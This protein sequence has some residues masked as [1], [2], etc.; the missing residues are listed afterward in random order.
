M[1]LLSPDLR[2]AILDFLLAYDE[3]L[4]SKGRIG[5]LKPALNGWDGIHQVNW[6]GSAY[7]F[8][9]HLLEITPGEWLKEALRAVPSGVDAAPTVSALCQRIEDDA[10]RATAVP[11]DALSRY[12]QEQIK[13]LSGSRYQ[14]DNR[15][16][17]L[18]LLVDQGPDAQGLRFVPDERRGKYNSLQTLLAEVQER[19]L[20][21]L[22]R[23]GCGKTTL[24]RRLQLERAWAGPEVAG[25]QIPFFVPLNS[26][27]GARL[28]DP[29][30]DPADWLAQ[31]WQQQQPDLPDFAG[32]LGKGRLLLL[33][34]GLNEM[35]HRDRDDFEER[36]ALW[37]LFV[38]RAAPLGNTL[39]FSC[40][41]LDYSVS[42]DSEAQPVRQVD[43]EPLTSA[44]IEQ[45]LTLYLGK[46]A[47]EV[48]A[49]LRQDSQQ[50]TLFATPFFL[51]LLVDQKL[52][53]GE[54]LTSRVAL[55]TGFVRRAL[56]RELE[57][58]H[59]RLFSPGQLLTAS[60]GQQVRQNKWATPMDLPQQGALIPRLA[61]LAYAMQDGRAA[62]EAGQIRIPEETA[63]ALLDHPLAAEIVAA[64]VQLNVLD[65]DMTRQEITCLHQLL[66]EYFAARVL[67]GRPEPGRVQSAWRADELQPRLTSWLKQADVSTPLPPA[68]TT[69]WEETT[70]L[71]AAL[72]PDAERFVGDLMAAN[73]PLAAR[74]A[75]VPEIAA[76]VPPGLLAELQGALLAR[77]GD[78]RADLRARIAAA[79]ALG[80]LGDPRFARR[81]GKHGDYLLP[82]VVSVS[83][84][85]YRIG[86]EERT[87]CSLLWRALGRRQ[88]AAYENEKPA[89]EV[90]IDTF[91]MAAFPAG[92]W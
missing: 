42:L 84:G 40:R 41:S 63:Y 19:A 22:G 87:G 12:Y 36:V 21:L 3:L 60:D 24:L 55:L 37:R 90:W 79:E 65:L 74:C 85:M 82:P 78:G 15:F 77:I 9:N 83:G 47:E 14:I 8:C 67:A 75:A 57:E 81:A 43:V 76:A 5:I 66:Q 92:E 33:L 51:R 68:P 56:Y 27:R 23:P 91:E 73:L 44:Q 46:E 72:T 16:V 35:P 64:G 49:A 50:L 7:V 38:R 30:P 62:D 39:L 31:Q 71:A 20:V 32:L 59:Q 6:E 25:E 61:A 1:S 17:Q 89:H 88:T 70:V 86:S 69:G 4:L 28:A 13:L 10:Q 18:T 54:L 48:W 53:S 26:Y 45:F 29:P 34:D 52:L 80:E 58:R 2:Q 11:A